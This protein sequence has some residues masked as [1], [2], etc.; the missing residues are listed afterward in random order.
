MNEFF[1]RL[2]IRVE[3]AEKIFLERDTFSEADYEK[4]RKQFMNSLPD[5]TEEVIKLHTG[6]E[7][8]LVYNYPLEFLESLRQNEE[9]FFYNDTI[10]GTARIFHLNTGNHAVIITAVDK[11]GIRVLKNLSTIIVL[12]VSGCIIVISILSHFISQR[13]IWPISRKIQRANM[14]SVRNFHERLI[15]Y[16]PDDELGELAIAF[17]NLLNR[18]E[19]AY[20][21]QK[22]FVSNASHEIRNPL[23]AILGEAEVI[24]ERD[25][26]SDEYKEALKNISA[27]ADR[28]NVLVNSLLQLSAVSYNSS[29][30]KMEDIPVELLLRQAKDKFDL[31]VPDNQVSINVDSLRDVKN[32]KVNGNINLLHTAL[33]NIFD[34]ASKFSSNDKVDVSV[35]IQSNLVM[36]SVSDNGIGIPAEDIPKITQP[37]F[38]AE[39]VR[40][41]RG[42]GIGI[43]LT[44]RIL[45]IHQGKLEVESEVNRGTTIK[46]VL[47]VA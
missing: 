13:M 38:R 36:I 10:Q 37:F 29:G 6:W 8:E 16:N 34:N 25:R 18:L 11:V 23:T 14:I 43:P 30:I 5:E 2:K 1:Q 15:V 26:S 31:L 47:P 28:L 41:I 9:A 32:V 12:A 40:Q 20:N 45:E 27:E 46:I 42:T 35:S 39:N 4:I 21:V 3:I 7:S 44:E 24:L 33:I 19:G 17:N 22:L